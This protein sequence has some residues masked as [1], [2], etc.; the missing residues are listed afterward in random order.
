MHPLH[1]FLFFEGEES[2]RLYFTSRYIARND[3]FAYGVA[4]LNAKR[5]CEIKM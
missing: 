4:R 3:K 5:A 2:S 1:L